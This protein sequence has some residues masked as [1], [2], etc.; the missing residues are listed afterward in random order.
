MSA[1]AGCK[2]P[3]QETYYSTSGDVLCRRCYYA[4][5]TRAQ[6]QRAMESLAAE[7][8]PGFKVAGTAPE[9]PASATVAGFVLLGASVTSVLFT[10]LLLGRIYLASALLGLLAFGGFARAR[11]IASQHG[12]GTGL[13]VAGLVL[14]VLAM[15]GITAVGLLGV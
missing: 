3:L 11:S 13:I 10:S 12:S 7:A 2:G 9:T 1:C 4:E 5:Q 14:S 8:P 15:L 6:D